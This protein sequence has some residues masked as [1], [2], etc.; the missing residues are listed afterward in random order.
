MIDEWENEGGSLYDEDLI[1]EED[2]FCPRCG[3]PFENPGKPCVYCEYDPLY[4]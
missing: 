1:F 2:E 3:E 4:D